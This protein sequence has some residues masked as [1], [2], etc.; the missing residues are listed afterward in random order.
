MTRL[1]DFSFFISSTFDHEPILIKMKYD[2]KGHLKSSFSALV[3]L[4]TA[5]S[6]KKHECQHKDTNFSLN[7][8]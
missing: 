6:L 1:W 2:L 4:F 7:E 3:F 8:V 5:Q